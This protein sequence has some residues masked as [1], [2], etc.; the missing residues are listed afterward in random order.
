MTL[1]E[2]L[3]ES[4]CAPAPAPDECPDVATWWPRH[5]R[6]VRE[7]SVPIERAIAGGLAADRAGWAFAAGYQAA[8]RALVPGLADDAIVAMCVTEDGGNRPSAIRTTLREAGTGRLRLDGAKRWTTLGPASAVLLVATV[9]LRGEAAEGGTSHA[10]GDTDAAVE[11]GVGS[12]T[13]PGE[14]A[15]RPLI[16]VARVAA[17]SP[18]VTLLPMPDT[19]FVPEVPHAR[20]EFAAV[21][22]AADALLP[23]DGY[24]GYVKPFRTVE[25]I[26]VSA[27][28]LAYLLTE[29]RRRGWPQDW[30]E[31]AI[32]SLVAFA[33]IAPRDPRSATTHLALAGVLAWTHALIAEAGTHFAQGPQD[34]AA[35]R[36]S[37]DASVAQ[38][39]ASARSQRAA[40]AWQRVDEAGRRR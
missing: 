13:R 11:A 39:A 37:R 18:G 31:R 15:P 30:C 34:E 40:R 16:R 14:R 25:D 38:V 7:R 36:W 35:Q 17:D 28:L 26:H 2:N 8:L 27:A 19:R 9:D 29:A 1:P 24:D 33:A 10:G 4:L 5:L 22:L 23:G 21:E 6:I 32:A 20:V 3:L 12:A